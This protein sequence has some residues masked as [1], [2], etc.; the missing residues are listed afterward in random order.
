MTLILLVTETVNVLAICC[1]SVVVLWLRCDVVSIYKYCSSK[2]RDSLFE[3]VSKAI[4]YCSG[5]GSL[6]QP[7]LQRYCV[8]L[9]TLETIGQIPM[10]FLCIFLR[11]YSWE[12]LRFLGVIQNSVMFL[13]SIPALW[14]CSSIRQI[15]LLISVVE[16]FCKCL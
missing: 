12:V 4:S 14:R 6:V 7:R 1:S 15:S 16:S 10:G 13:S 9:L 8:T 3:S 2:C 11:K 5:L